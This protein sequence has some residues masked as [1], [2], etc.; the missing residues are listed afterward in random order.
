MGRALRGLPT[1]GLAG[2][3]WRGSATLQGKR[4]VLLKS[5]GDLGHQEARVP[6]MSG[7][8]PQRPGETR[9]APDAP[10]EG[11]NVGNGRCPERGPV[12]RNTGIRERVG[13]LATGSRTEGLFSILMNKRPKVELRGLG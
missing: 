11:G 4:T 3:A 5:T 8:G 2:V 1:L 6:V 9:E 13:T 7:A 12:A 10:A